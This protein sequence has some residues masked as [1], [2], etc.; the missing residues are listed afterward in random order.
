MSS[1][2]LHRK[3]GLNPALTTCYFCNE[4]SGI[5]L[6]GAEVKKFKEVGLADDDG[7]MKMNIG[8]IDTRPCSKCED[9]MKKGIILISIRDDAT[10]EID[11][12]NI[13][14]RIPNPYRTGGWCVVT[15]DYIRRMIADPKLV[16]H[17][18][19]KRMAFIPDQAWDVLGLPRGE[20]KSG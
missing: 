18:L 10:K 5:L 3:H 4:A 8:V 16:E 14:Q 1:I 6:A 15:E 20:N 12:A 13:E 9:L 11:S 17:V 2:H 7:R 19:K